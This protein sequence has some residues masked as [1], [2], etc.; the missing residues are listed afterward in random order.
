[1]HDVHEIATKGPGRVFVTTAYI[2]TETIAW[3]CSTDADNSSTSNCNVRVTRTH[4]PRVDCHNMKVVS[5]I[6]QVLGGVVLAVGL[7]CTCT[8]T[9]TV[10]PVGIEK[11][12]IS[13]RH[14]YKTADLPY[15]GD[16]SVTTS[17]G[18]KRPLHTRFVDVFQDKSELYFESGATITGTL[19]RWLAMAD[20]N[21]DTKN[22]DEPLDER[23]NGYNNHPFYRTT[24][25][26]L[27][28]EL[29][30]SNRNYGTSQPRLQA[31]SVVAIGRVSS[32]PGW[33]GLGALPTIFLVYPRGEPNNQTFHTI[34]HYRQGV[35]I[36]FSGTGYVY[37]FHLAT[38]VFA[39][40]ASIVMLSVAAAVTDLVAINLCAPTTPAKTRILC[41]L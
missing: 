21:L 16:S 38:C 39:L 33:A 31:D 36:N 20:V 9:S 6:R 25:V 13:V 28:V 26:Q 35:V 30:Y 23:N 34:K 41:S 32:E 22:M 1:M 15:V 27:N 29:E 18:H 11:M 2:E 17:D 37:K 3:P 4:L 12:T 14:T 24:G 19:E 10:Y 5:H 8:L 40:A 7:Q